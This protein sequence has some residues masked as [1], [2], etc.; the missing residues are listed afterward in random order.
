MKKV[1]PYL[2]VA[3]FALISFASPPA[4]AFGLRL[5][6]F[7]LGVPLF[8]H[9]HYHHPLYMHGNTNDVARHEISRRP[10]NSIP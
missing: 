4:A 2:A 7:H 6:P 5:G 10:R 9:R 8:G 3:A 1:G